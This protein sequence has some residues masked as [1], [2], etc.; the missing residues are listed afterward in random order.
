MPLVP[1]PPSLNLNAQSVEIPGSRQDGRSGIWKS[2]TWDRSR[3]TAEGEPRTLHEVFAQ[4]VARHPSRDMFLRRPLLS[5]PPNPPQYGTTLIP[6]TYAAIEARRAAL[7]SALLGLER[8][9]KLGKPSEI[10]FAGIPHFGNANRVKGG[11]RRGWGVGVWSK[12]REEWQVVDLATHSYGLVGVSLYETLG[13]DV[14]QYITNHCPLSVVFAAA[15]HLPSLLKI[16][17][18]CPSLKAIVTMDVL[19]P[20]ERDVLTQ[21]AASVG[22]ELLDM[23]EMEKWGSL[24]ENKIEP[25]PVKGVPGE[26]EL[27]EQRIVTISYTSGTTGDPK[28]V[29]LTNSNLTTAVISNSL[30]TTEALTSGEW[31]FISYLPLSHIYERFLQLVVMY[32]DGTIGLTTGDTLRL[33][34]DAQLIKPHFFPGVPRIFNRIN[35]AVKVQMAAGGLKGALLKK[36]VATKMENWRRDGTVTHTLYDAL[37]FR[38]I[39]AL[40]GGSVVYISSGAAPLAPEVHEMLK[41]CFSCEVIQGF[42]MTESIGTCTKGI[43]WDIN[44]VGTCGPIQPCNDLVLMDV[45]DMGYTSKDKPNPRGELCL[46]GSNIFLGYL[47]DPENTAKTIDKEG[48]MHTGDI[49]EIDAQGR[50]K[51]IDRMK[52]VVK[53]SQGEYVALEK[54]EGVYALDPLFA[55]LL[56]HGDS[57]RSHLIAIAVLD[58]VQA[59]AFV[60]TVTGKSVAATDLKALDELCNDKRVRSMVVKKFAKVAKENKLNGFEMI[61]GVHLTIQPFSD[62]LMTPTLKV[63]RNIAAKKFKKEIDAVYEETENAMTEAKL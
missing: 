19:P 45:A 25:G 59:A 28:G 44:A 58:P 15:N 12:N 54:L 27:D 34:E 31:R 37:V 17:P 22:V 51:I 38:K 16:A 6:A 47:H 41:I 10:T 60:S 24:E 9:G 39:R 40:L 32:G 50:L 62:D 21:W 20:A 11:A 26:A 2:G 36:A 57:L 1:Y 52:N 35:A 42:G 49:G 33:L 4:S 55:T 14:A 3:L 29:V 61:K 8:E 23:A 13:P 30:G 5:S 63:K 18:K 56:V 48:W 46:R 53:L 43:A 7:G